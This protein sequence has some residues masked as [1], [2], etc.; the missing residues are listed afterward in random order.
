M[1]IRV[2]TAGVN[3]ADDTCEEEL[4]GSWSDFSTFGGGSDWLGDVEIHV[5]NKSSE[6]SACM[7]S[8]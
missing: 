3:R 6:L 5:A 4:R 8:V 2:D 7:P 1:V